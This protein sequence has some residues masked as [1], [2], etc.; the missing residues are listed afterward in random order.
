[1]KISKVIFHIKLIFSHLWW[2]CKNTILFQIKKDI[3][4]SNVI[5]VKELF[6]AESYT[7]QFRGVLIG[8][9]SNV[10]MLDW[11]STLPILPGS[12]L[13]VVDQCFYNILLYCE[14]LGL[15]ADGF[16]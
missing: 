7:E 9:K 13:L 12:L 4:I 11:K 3:E 8:L 1:M 10:N 6:T 5:K 15:A 2:E 16:N 14:F